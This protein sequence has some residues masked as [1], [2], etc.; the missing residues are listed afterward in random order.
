VVG[1]IVQNNFEHVYV[2]APPISLKIH[3][4]PLT[5][6]GVDPPRSCFHYWLDRGCGTGSIFSHMGSMSAAKAGPPLP[7]IGHSSPP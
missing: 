6:S 4:A 3:F 1:R 5:K 7:S 2:L